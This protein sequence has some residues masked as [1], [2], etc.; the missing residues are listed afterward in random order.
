[1]ADLDWGVLGPMACVVGLVVAFAL[2]VIFGS[3]KDPKDPN[4]G[5]YANPQALQKGSPKSARRQEWEER[6]EQREIHRITPP[7][8]VDEEKGGDVCL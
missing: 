8:E 2:V 3:K 5:K 4:E 7:G 6:V 1:M